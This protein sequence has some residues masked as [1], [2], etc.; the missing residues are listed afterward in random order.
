MI[1]YLHLLRL[2]AV[3]AALRKY[4]SGSVLDMGGRDF[5][6]N[7][8]SD[9]SIH[10]ENWTCLELDR[11][12]V[13]IPDKRYKLVIGD[14]ENAPFPD[15]TFE[16]VINMQVLEHTM[17]P[18]TMVK[19]VARVLK[20]KGFSIFLIPQ[21]SV[22]HEIPTHYYNFTRYW[23]RHAFKEAGLEIIEL[24]PL[25]GRWSTHASHMF[26]FFLEAFRVPG[27]SSTEYPRTFFFYLLFP[28]MA[29]YALLGICI[30]MIFSIGDLSEDPNNLLV[31]ARKSQVS[32]NF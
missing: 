1:K 13:D 12:A 21:T 7:I 27:Y 16:T 24:H 9:P 15:A 30:G 19:E 22:A 32:G 8:A 20:D 11:S 10:F 2:R 31:V 28:I 17:H 3:F 18:I 25:G 14:G 6:S 29:L 4:T 5:F 26:F 23:V